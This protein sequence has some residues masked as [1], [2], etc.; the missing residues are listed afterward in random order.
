MPFWAFLYI[1]NI[2]QIIVFDLRYL[3]STFQ[4][5]HPGCCTQSTLGRLSDPKLIKG[6]RCLFER[7]TPEDRVRC[8]E[9]YSE[10]GAAWPNTTLQFTIVPPEK[11]TSLL[12]C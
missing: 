9:P 5:V 10:K 4:D 8:Q 11:Y 1:A 2:L 12:N 3:F 6:Y 7:A